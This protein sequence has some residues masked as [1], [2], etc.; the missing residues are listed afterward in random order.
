[1]KFALFFFGINFTL[2]LYQAVYLPYIV[3]TEREMEQR[4]IHIGALSG[5][6]GGLFLVI[7]CWP[8]WG[9]ATIPIFFSIFFGFLN[10]NHFMPGGKL[11]NASLYFFVD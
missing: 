1:M 4:F 6:L 8:V 10:L 7:A 11:G 2:L 9:Y 5:L 3:G